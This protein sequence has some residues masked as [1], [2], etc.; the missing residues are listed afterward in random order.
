MSL[1]QSVLLAI[2]SFKW[3]NIA[4]HLKEAGEI[5]WS[6]LTTLSI[7][8]VKALLKRGNND[9]EGNFYHLLLVKEKS[10]INSL[11]KPWKKLKMKILINSG[12]KL[13]GNQRN[14]VLWIQNWKEN[15]K[16]PKKL[17]K[18]FIHQNEPE[19]FPDTVEVYYKAIFVKSFNLVLDCNY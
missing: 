3:G 18:Y 13:W 15:P 5:Y 16:Y 4:Y 1:L 11:P 6:L 12:N 10:C 8:V 19:N 7:L 9:K 17:A 14:F 2:S